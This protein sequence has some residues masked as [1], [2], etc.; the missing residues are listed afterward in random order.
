MATAWLKGTNADFREVYLS[1][2]LLCFVLC[3]LHTQQ[4][5]SKLIFDQL[6]NSSW[7]TVLFSKQLQQK[8]CGWFSLDHR[9]TCAPPKWAYSQRR[10]KCRWVICLK[11]N[12]WPQE[13]E[14]WFPKGKPGPLTWRKRLDTAQANKTQKQQVSNTS[15]IWLSWI[16]MNNKAIN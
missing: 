16:N 13:R 7:K 3:W 1:I 5:F 8:S 10:G 14:G 9:G 12:L 15:S 2:S 11:G 4:H 6:S